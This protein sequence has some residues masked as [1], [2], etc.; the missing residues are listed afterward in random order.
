MLDLR[1]IRE[2]ADLV[3]KGVASKGED[4]SMVDEVIQLDE[5]RRERIQHGEVL[6]NRRNTVS[7]Q[8][9]RLKAEKNDAA[10][11]IAEMKTVSDEIKATDSA[12][13]EI[14]ENVHRIL[15]QIPNTPHPSVPP[16]KTPEE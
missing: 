12:L 14:E 8:V 4:P 7:A 16:G 15:L 6:K 5:K 3:K 10:S 2:N 9:A 1:H 13:K 11:L